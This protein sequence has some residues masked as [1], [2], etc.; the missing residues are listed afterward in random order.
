MKEGRNRTWGGG[1]PSRCAVACLVKIETIKWEEQMSC[2]TPV[3]LSLVS[4]GKGKRLHFTAH[5]LLQVDLV[6][7]P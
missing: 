6:G 1:G 4:A 3:N 5:K 7:R 2:R